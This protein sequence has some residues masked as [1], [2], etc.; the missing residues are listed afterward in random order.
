MFTISYLKSKVR[1]LDRN[2]T[3]LKQIGTTRRLSGQEHA[4]LLALMKEQTS[5]AKRL[6]QEKYKEKS[7]SY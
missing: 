4:N 6:K 5:K 3:A 1:S 7:G 2:I